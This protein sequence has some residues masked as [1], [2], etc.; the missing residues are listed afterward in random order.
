M[1]DLNTEELIF[2]AAREVFHE[3][4]Y[5]GARMQE[6]ARRAGI[7]QSMLHYYFRS[8]EK[9]FDAVFRKAITT[10]VPVVLAALRDDK[11]LIPKIEAFVSVYL[12]TISSNPHLPAFIFEELRRNPDMLREIVN[13]H[14][15]GVFSVFARQVREAVEDGVIAPIEPE[16]LFINIIGLCVFPI[17]GRPMLQTVTGLSDDKYDSLL[18]SRKE[19]VTRFILSAIVL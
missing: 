8:K 4:G 2:E 18:A 7:N 6:I 11:P 12:D 19:T 16:Q 3:Q 14:S 1:K 17:I 9:L 13:S 10:A 15:D 5:G